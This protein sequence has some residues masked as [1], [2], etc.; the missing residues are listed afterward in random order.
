M[1]ERD[2]DDFL[3]GNCECFQS[4]KL[5]AGEGKGRR[6]VKANAKTK[7]GQLGRG[8]PRKGQIREKRVFKLKVGRAQQEVS[9]ILIRTRTGTQ[10]KKAKP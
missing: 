6:D 1:E 2:W 4:E 7:G 3:H 5:G 8:I 10:K 9:V